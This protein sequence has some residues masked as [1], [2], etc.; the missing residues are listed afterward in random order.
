METKFEFQ[1]DKFLFYKFLI[2]QLKN[3]SFTSFINWSL[4]LKKI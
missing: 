3:W 1:T 2:L 4:L